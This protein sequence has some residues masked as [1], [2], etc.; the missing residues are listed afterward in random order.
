MLIE[1]LVECAF[2]LYAY[3]CGGEEDPDLSDMDGYFKRQREQ[4]LNQF[5][6]KRMQLYQ[7]MEVKREEACIGIQAWWRGARLRK[8]E[9]RRKAVIRIQALWRG[10]YARKKIGSPQKPLNAISQLCF[11]VCDYFL[12]SVEQN[13]LSE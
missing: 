3:C 13:F 4:V 8:Q 7:T 1:F 5:L 2:Q 9:T 6:L 11:V 12:T 10:S